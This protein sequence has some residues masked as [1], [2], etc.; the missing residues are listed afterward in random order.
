MS[1]RKHRTSCKS[2]KGVWGIIDRV[3]H[4]LS[5]AL[6][7]GHGMIITGFVLGFIFAPLLTAIVF[8]VT[9]Y[10]VSYPRQARRHL[11][12]VSRYVRRA[13]HR[14][15]DAAFA[16]KADDTVTEP[17]FDAEPP[18]PKRPRATAAELKER[19]EALDKR[20]KSIEAFVTSQEYRLEREFKRMDDQ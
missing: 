6:G 14:L 16:S 1:K 19:F 4:G 5:E 2:G 11:E 13:G 12:S 20:A 3:V 8:L 7:L 9:L 10:W 18:A 15:S 17:A